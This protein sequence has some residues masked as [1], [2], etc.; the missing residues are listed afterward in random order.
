MKKFVLLFASVLCTICFCVHPFAMDTSSL[1]ISINNVDIIFDDNSTLT[2]EEKQFVAEYL[3]TGVDSTQTYGLICN[4]F[5]HKNTTE[6]VTTITHR[7]Y[8]TAPR[9]FEEEWEIITCSRC[10]NT[11]TTRIAYA[12]INCCPEE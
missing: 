4:L 11:E 5:G 10:G 8:T 9:C 12:L 1:V 6:I 7:A 2:L 3:V